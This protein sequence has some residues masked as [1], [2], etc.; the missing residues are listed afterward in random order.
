MCNNKSSSGTSMQRVATLWRH[1]ITE[2]VESITKHG[3]RV[4]QRVQ[5]VDSG[6]EGR[7]VRNQMYNQ[8]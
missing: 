1:V 3:D 4:D 5:M 8:S 2:A 7:K 6:Q